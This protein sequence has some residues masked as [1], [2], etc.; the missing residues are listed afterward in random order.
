MHARQRLDSWSEPPCLRG[1][2]VEGGEWRV[3]L[4]QAAI[5]AA[6]LLADDIGYADSCCT[7]AKSDSIR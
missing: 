2:D 5:L 7:V 4:M 6:F 1:L 3:I